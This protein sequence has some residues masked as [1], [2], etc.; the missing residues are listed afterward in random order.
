MRIFLNSLV[1]FLSWLHLRRPRTAPLAARA[2]TLLSQGQWEVIARFRRLAHVWGRQ[3]SL[4]S[5]DLGRT[6]CK[7]ENM[8]GILQGLFSH[9]CAVGSTLDPY[10]RSSL[11]KS[12]TS[13]VAGFNR[14]DPHTQVVGF[15]SCLAL[16]A[17]KPI[18]A[19]RIPFR[20]T[21]SFDPV[22]WMILIVRYTVYGVYIIVS[23][24]RSMGDTMDSPPP[25][26]SPS[27]PPPQRF[28]VIAV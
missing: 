18:V 17:A 23:P 19:E 4:L 16:Q 10:S 7:V 14:R 1:A 5:T 22:P 13:R 25:P 2:G 11:C 12:P 15:L 21:P 27:P 28:L 26:L 9:A 20:D 6:T 24:R 3:E 8:E